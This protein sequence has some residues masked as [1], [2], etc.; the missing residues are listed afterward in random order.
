M[1]PSYELTPVE[2]NLIRK[3]ILNDEIDNESAIYLSKIENN[4]NKL[5]HTILILRGLLS[6]DILYFILSKRWKV[7]YGVNENSERGLWQAVPFRAKDVAAERAQFAHPDIAIGLTQL[8]YYYS[9]LAQKQLEETFQILEKSP[10]KSSIYEQWIKQLPKNVPVD[11]SIKEYAKLNLADTTQ[12]YTRLFPTLKYHQPVIDYW[13]S[14]TVYPKESKEFESR[15]SASMWDL[16]ELNR[17][18]TVGFSGTNELNILLPLAMKYY[19]MPN[20]IGT[21]G[22]VL[23]NLYCQNND[24]DVYNFFEE[25]CDELKMLEKITENKIPV[26]LDVGALIVRMSNEEVAMKWLELN[27]QKN[28]NSLIEACVFFKGNDLVVMERNSDDLSSWHT[29]SFET[30]IYK[31]N[32]NNKCLI[33]LDESHCRGTDLRFKIYI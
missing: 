21:S 5:K 3:Y 15:I 32:M 33:Y 29:T 11:D 30:S 13:L 19:P 1:V 28:K 18:L 25:K 4:K 7:Q 10:D 24:K 31:E 26:L 12:T 16:C 23:A 27:Q 9:G 6:Y 2:K 22:K 17:N 8:S 20:L 14:N